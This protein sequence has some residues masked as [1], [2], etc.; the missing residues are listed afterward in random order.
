MHESNDRSGT[1]GMFFGTKRWSATL[2]FFGEPAGLPSWSVKG[3][4]LQVVMGINYMEWW[5]LILR[6]IGAD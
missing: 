1:L 4:K 2:E 6:H 3:P 5:D